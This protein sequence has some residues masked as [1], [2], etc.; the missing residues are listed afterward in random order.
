MTKKERSNKEENDIQEEGIK[1]ETLEPENG[2]TEEITAE[3]ILA[4]QLTEAL[5]ESAK[6]LD[7]WQRTQAEFSNYRKRME[8][9]QVRMRE[10]AASRVTRQILP[11]VDDLT[12]A[13]KDRPQE[14]EAGEWAAGIELVYRKLASVLEQEGVSRMETEG[15]MFDPNFHEAIAQV[16]SPEHESGQIVE[17]IQEG[18]MIG[19]RV[20]RAALV[21]VAI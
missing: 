2:E 10:D 14:G 4:Q 11:V 9:D 12:R 16:E 13:L 19:E 17:V 21:R 15:E 20:L 5:D 7:G 3:A 1:A 18:Y 6:N 8:R